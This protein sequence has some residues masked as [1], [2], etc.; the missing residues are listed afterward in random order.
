VAARIGAVG[1]GLQR[2][3]AQRPDNF[4][5]NRYDFCASSSSALRLAAL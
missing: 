4:D 5:C 3:P 2:S 1:S